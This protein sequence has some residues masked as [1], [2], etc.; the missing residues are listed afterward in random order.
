LSLLGANISLSTLFSK[1]LSQRS[2]VNVSDQVS[3]TYKTT[4][5]VISR[6]SSI[7]MVGTEIL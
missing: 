3:H 5:K 1:T 2:S 6:S 4:I 7:K